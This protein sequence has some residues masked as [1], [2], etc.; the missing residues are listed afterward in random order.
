MQWYVCPKCDEWNIKPG[1]CDECKE[2]DV[3]PVCIVCG[4]EGK[5]NKEPH[6]NHIKEWPKRLK[7]FREKMKTKTKKKIAKNQLKQKI[8]GKMMIDQVI[9]KYPSSIEVF[10]Q[11][12]LHCIGCMASSA[13]TIGQ[14]AL[15]HGMKKKDIE[16]L[17]KDLNSKA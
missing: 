4:K 8:T 17:I 16:K 11:H 7:E 6:F 13:E 14:G 5:V 10:M 2:G 3:K 15:A 12:G 1:K 9:Q